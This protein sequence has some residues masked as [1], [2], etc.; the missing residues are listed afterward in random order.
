MN[1]LDREVGGK[2]IALFAAQKDGKTILRAVREDGVVF[3]PFFGEWR[4]KWKV[5]EEVSP[6]EYVEHVRQAADFFL[7]L[8]ASD[9][10]DWEVLE[11]WLE[12]GIAESI[13]G[14]SVELDGHCPHGWPSWPL[15][16]GLI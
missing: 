5:K 13:D 16:M 2:V 6:H 12:E 4:A 11:E 15:V 14:C 1:K 8:K 7:P 10:P 3:A 9:V